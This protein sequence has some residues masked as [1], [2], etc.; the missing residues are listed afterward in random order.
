MKIIPSS[1]KNVKDQRSPKTPGQKWVYRPYISRSDGGN[2]GDCLHALWSLPWCPWNAP[3]EVNNLLIGCPLLKKK[4]HGALALSKIKH[5]GLNVGRFHSCPSPY[6]ATYN[7]R[8]FQFVGR[9]LCLYLV[10]LLN[11]DNSTWKIL[12]V[13]RGFYCCQ[14]LP[15]PSWRLWTMCLKGGGMVAERGQCAKKVSYLYLYSKY[16]N[17]LCRWSGPNVIKPVGTEHLLSTDKY[18]LTEIV[19]QLKLH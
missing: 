19:H 11:R 14:W 15:V 13:S 12:A 2:G 6:L 16:K 10:M 5:T 7:M 9:F 3:V 17:K 8:I 4:C 18:C 1:Q